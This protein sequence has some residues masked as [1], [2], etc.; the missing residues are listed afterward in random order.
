M[1]EKQRLTGSEAIPFSIIKFLKK[2]KHNK[3]KITP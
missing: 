1:E 3:I 2:K